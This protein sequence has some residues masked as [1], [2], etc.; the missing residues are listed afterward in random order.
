MSECAAL[1]S[2]SFSRR[3]W[4]GFSGYPTVDCQ[5]L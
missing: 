5:A 1:I 4:A 3:C 2:A